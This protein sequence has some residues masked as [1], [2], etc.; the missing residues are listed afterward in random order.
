MRLKNGMLL[1]AQ[2]YCLKQPEEASN[3]ISLPNSL[4]QMSF[5][6]PDIVFVHH[7]PDVESSQLHQ[8]YVFIYLFVS[9]FSVEPR[10]FVKYEV[11]QTF[12]AQL[13]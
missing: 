8:L 11:Y 6:K 9:V 13:F 2:Q 1:P 5:S 4:S 7:V 12:S 3:H 10:G